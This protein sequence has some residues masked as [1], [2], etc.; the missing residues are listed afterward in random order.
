MNK[1]GKSYILLDIIIVI[2]LAAV[3]ISFILPSKQIDDDLKAI[4]NTEK[5]LSALSAGIDIY[6]T[7]MDGEMPGKEGESVQAIFSIFE[8]LKEEKILSI[9]EI[10][11]EQMKGYFE[12]GIP[13]TKYEFNEDQ[14]SFE[15]VAYSKDRAPHK[16]VM[17]QEELKSID[18]EKRLVEILGQIEGLNK[19]IKNQIKKFK[20]IQSRAE[21]IDSFITNAKNYDGILSD[22]EQFTKLE[23]NLEEANSLEDVNKKLYNKIRNNLN[24]LSVSIKKIENIKDS[25]RETVRNIGKVAIDAEDYLAGLKTIKNYVKSNR[26]KEMASEFMV[27]AEDTKEH[28]DDVVD[29]LMPQADELAKTVD[30]KSEFLEEYNQKYLEYRDKF[31]PLNNMYGEFKKGE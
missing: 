14:K 29:K 18:P 28:A 27:K 20:L 16:F 6:Y 17:D 8:D 22:E 1:Q 24:N 31:Q 21:K 7:K 10:D 2:L 9:L 30:N 3:V 23:N 19:D 25:S 4:T 12:K 26:L 13:G 11:V 15:I 5:A